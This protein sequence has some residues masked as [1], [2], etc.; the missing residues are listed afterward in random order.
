MTPPKTQQAWKDCTCTRH[1]YTTAV[2]T[3]VTMIPLSREQE[4]FLL[5]NRGRLVCFECGGRVDDQFHSVADYVT[6]GTVAMRLSELGVIP[7]G[8]EA[9]R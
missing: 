4:S 2:I 8:S 9:T 5:E 7:G 1:D 6:G 3:P